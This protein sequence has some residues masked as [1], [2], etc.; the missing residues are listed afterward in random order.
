MAVRAGA[1]SRA[2]FVLCVGFN[3]LELSVLGLYIVNTIHISRFV[4][5]IHYCINC[6]ER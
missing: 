1:V 6:K 3:V 5:D 2:E 4:K